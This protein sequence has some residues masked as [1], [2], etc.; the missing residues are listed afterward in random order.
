VTLGYTQVKLEKIEGKQK[1][2]LDFQT[3][4]SVGMIEVLK[5][6]TELSDVTKCT[7]LGCFYIHQ[8]MEMA[9][10]I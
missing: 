9:E 6:K 7:I 4:I 2:N 8:M 1:G 3:N 10:F 5:A